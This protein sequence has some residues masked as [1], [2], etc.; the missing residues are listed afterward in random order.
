MSYIYDRNEKRKYSH[1]EIKKTMNN[2]TLFL[3]KRILL[4]NTLLLV[5]FLQKFHKTQKNS[6]KLLT[7]LLFLI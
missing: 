1:K 7:L 4:A 2:R 6:K 5:F 3:C